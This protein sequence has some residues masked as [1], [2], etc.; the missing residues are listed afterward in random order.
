MAA[1]T[2]PRG[3]EPYL[4]HR[5]HSVVGDGVRSDREV[6]SRV[7]A[8]DPVDGVPVWRVRLVGV[9]HRQVSHRHADTILW[10]LARKLK[11]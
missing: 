8:D 11:I 10:D 9:A 6:S 4:D 1:N 2:E 7:P 3:L 5:D